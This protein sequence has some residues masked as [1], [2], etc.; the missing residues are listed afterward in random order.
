MGDLLTVIDLDDEVL[1][2]DG[3]A[4][5]HLAICL[6]IRDSATVGLPINQ[7]REV[8]FTPCGQCRPDST[9]AAQA[10]RLRR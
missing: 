8:G 1:V 9:L 5:Y 7:A 3:R 6:Y 10:R 4:H 2:I